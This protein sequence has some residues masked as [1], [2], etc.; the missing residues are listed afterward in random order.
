MAR[1]LN[2]GRSLDGAEISIANV[3][4]AGSSSGIHGTPKI[5]CET[6]ANILNQ[7]GL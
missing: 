6:C 3:R 5:P 4:G 1:A 2:K 7:F